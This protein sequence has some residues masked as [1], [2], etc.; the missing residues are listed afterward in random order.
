MPPLVAAC[1]NCAAWTRFPAP[2]GA[3]ATT[4]PPAGACRLG[5]A[6][7]PGEPRCDR[8]MVSASFEREIVGRMMQD[9]TVVPVPLRGR[10]RRR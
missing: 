10:K 9:P 1:T 7:P 4:A 5:L 6:P 3:H 2:P 8:Y